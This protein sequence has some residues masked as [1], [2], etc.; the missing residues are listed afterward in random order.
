MIDSHSHYNS[1]LCKDLDEKIMAVN[2]CHYVDKI[3]NVGLDIGTSKEITKLS[4]NQF[5]FYNSIGIH[6]LYLENNNIL[7]LLDI[8]NNNPTKIIAIGEIGLDK[9]NDNLEEQINMFRAQIELSNYLKIPVIIHSSGYNALCLKILREMK[10]LYKYVFHCF[11]PDLDIAKEI[12]SDGGF[13]SVAGKITY[14]TA[15][16]SLELIRSIPLTNLFIETDSPYI[17]PEPYRDNINSSL[18]ISV[19]A[20]KVA[21]VKGIDIDEVSE[22]TSENTKRL[23]YKIK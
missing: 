11:E 7:E 15:K 3:I 1:L 4:N 6:P 21:E 8:Y 22:I 17:S 13:V 14:K 20:N 12:V 5:K 2:N 16:K 18:N 9:S 23:F 10:T 19:I